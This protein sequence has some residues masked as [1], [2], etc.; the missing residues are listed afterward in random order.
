MEPVAEWGVALV[1][2][3]GWVVEDWVVANS[4]R[5]VDRGQ[6]FLLPPDMAEW[7]PPGHLVW[8]LID[9][10]EELD[11]SAFHAGRVRVGQ[12]R[13]GFDP[14]MLVTLLM[15]A[16][17]N[18][19]RSSR[20]I[21]RLCVT[22]VAFRVICAQDVPDH[23][24]IARFRAE[25]EDGFAELFTRVLVLCAQA[26]M[27]RVGVVAID[28]TKIAA[29]ASLGANRKEEWLREQAAKQAAAIVAE[30]AATDAAEDEE[31]GD[32]RGDELPEKFADRS[33]RRERIR[34]ALDEIGKQTGQA[35]RDDAAD[36]ARVEEYLARVEAG[37]A[38]PGK[39]PAG[40]DLVRLHAARLARAEARL[41]AA[42]AGAGAGNREARNT[43]R[44]HLRE[45]RRDLTAAEAAAAAG[46][47]DREGASARRRR[48]RGDPAPV[49]NTSDPDSRKM[50][51][52][53]GGII[54]GFNAQ[55]AVTDDHLILATALTQDTNDYHCFEPMTNA[56]I[57][58]TEHITRSDQLGTILADAG[59][60]SEHNLT[61]N[62]P[63]RLIAPGKHR[64][65]TR[66]AR[67]RPAQGPPPPEATP[68]EQMQHR[69]RTPE[70]HTTYKRRSATV[71]TV[72]GHLK[73]QT[74]LRRFSRRGL[75]AAASELTLAATVINLLKLRNHTLQPAT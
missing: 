52:R 4:Y 26:G 22:D 62:G 28:G 27:G 38:V 20:Q 6:G 2:G 1:V 45:A 31:F 65:I 21:E 18:K 50:S 19:V 14:D 32:R 9:A 29:N 30:A 67:D 70:G 11:T 15:Y 33:G 63:D 8:F 74:G 43:A 13:A 66:D 24:T 23:T 64:D 53:C 17:A 55:L 46:T 35:G 49:A 68:G 41:A 44:R 54:Q 42:G 25:H 60:W 71:E 10:V 51:T 69:I 73:D 12:G 48:R 58:A 40:T 7:L 56:V 72:I 16:Y 39:P 47:A 37:E 61:L 36:R 75:K 3:V 57:T 34:K 59:Y 5:P